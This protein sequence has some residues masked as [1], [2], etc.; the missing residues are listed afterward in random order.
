MRTGT[1]ETGSG[2]GQFWSKPALGRA[3]FYPKMLNRGRRMGLFG[4]YGAHIYA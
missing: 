1:A 3:K 4:Y 2:E